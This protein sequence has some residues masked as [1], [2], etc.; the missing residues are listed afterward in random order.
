MLLR[1]HITGTYWGNV[2][3][4]ACCEVIES[5]DFHLYIGPR[6]NDYNTTGYTC[7]IKVGYLVISTLEHTKSDQ[8]SFTYSVD[9]SLL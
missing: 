2:S 4:T 9:V 3:S 8:V 5:A 6:F 1:G 7:L